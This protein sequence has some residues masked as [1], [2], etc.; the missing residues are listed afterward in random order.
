M[1]G[2]APYLGVSPFLNRK[3]SP[4]FAMSS[5]LIFVSSTVRPIFAAMTSGVSSIGESFRNTFASSSEKSS[6]SSSIS[7][8][9]SVDG[10]PRE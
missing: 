6:L 8:P 1:K 4:L 2:M 5:S 7:T 9:D 10:K 3:R